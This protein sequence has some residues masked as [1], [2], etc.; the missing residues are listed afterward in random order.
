MLNF[1]RQKVQNYPTGGKVPNKTLILIGYLLTYWVFIDGI[2]QTQCKV[3]RIYLCNK[4]PFIC[5]DGHTDVQH[6]TIILRHYHVAGYKK[7]DKQQNQE[8]PI[9]SPTAFGSGELKIKYKL[10]SSL[11]HYKK[12]NQFC[13]GRQFNCLPLQNELLLSGISS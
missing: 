8:A 10:R 3:S 9:S 6:E 11:Y 7:D 12:R 2:K 5:S 4:W 1:H 13:N